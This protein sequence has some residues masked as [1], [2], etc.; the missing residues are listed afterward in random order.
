MKMA[1]VMEGSSL[2]WVFKLHV[3]IDMNRM[4]RA[5]R[6]T[7]VVGRSFVSC[8]VLML[9]VFQNSLYS[10]DTCIRLMCQASVVLLFYFN[11]LKHK[12]KY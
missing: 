12:K 4:L 2:D 5:K 7:Y 1:V 8:N 9:L 11:I 10:I 3:S 6:R